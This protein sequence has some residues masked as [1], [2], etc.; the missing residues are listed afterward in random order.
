MLGRMLRVFVTAMSV[1]CV[2]AK[3]VYV[4][5]LRVCWRA[6][7]LRGAPGVLRLVSVG[8]CRCCQV[9]CVI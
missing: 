4:P 9:G 3:A 6:C 1:V 8:V 5:R 2:Q 7:C